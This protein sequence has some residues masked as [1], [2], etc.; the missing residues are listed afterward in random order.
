MAGV[1]KTSWQKNFA[2]LQYK[3]VKDRIWQ[4]KSD[5]TKNLMQ[6]KIFLRYNRL[7]YIHE[8]E[9]CAIHNHHASCDHISTYILFTCLTFILFIISIAVSG[10]LVIQLNFG[11]RGP[12]ILAEFCKPLFLL[13]HILFFLSGTCSLKLYLYY[14]INDHFIKSHGKEKRSLVTLAS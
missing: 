8:A 10:L 6:V 12:T 11:E 14:A 9:N 2:W 5:G 1:E 13:S 7:K 4:N 3:N